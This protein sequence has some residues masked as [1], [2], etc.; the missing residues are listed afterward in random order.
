MTLSPTAESTLILRLL[1]ERGALRGKSESDVARVIA[2][3]SAGAEET[4]VANGLAD[5]KTIA[6]AYAKHLGIP[7][8]ESSAAASNARALA[9]APLRVHR[10]G[11]APIEIGS[12][13]AI[14]ESCRPFADLV[15]EEVCRRARV[16]PIGVT[17]GSLDLACA[18]P[19]SF[20]MLEEVQLR[21]GL[22]VRA[23]AATLSVADALIAGFFAKP[24]AEAAVVPDAAD[25]TAQPEMRDPD[26]IDLQRNTS[27]GKDDH[28]L[29]IVRILLR[30]AI[31]QG[32]SDVHLEPD[33]N[34][35]RVRYRIDGKLVDVAPPPPELFRP[36]IARVMRLAKAEAGDE[37][38][39][40]C[41]TF[42][43]KHFER[44]FHFRASTVPTVHGERMLVR[45]LDI[46]GA[47]A[48]FSDLG[49][50]DAPSRALLEAVRAR[51]LVLLA[52]EHG[53][54]TTTT[55]YAC[56]RALDPAV[57]SVASVEDP[58]EQR[59][60]RVN[61]I[62]ARACGG[63]DVASAL[64]AVLRQDPDVIAV[65]ELR[66]A[67]T[68]RVAIEA[69]RSGRSVIAA[70]RAASAL[71]ALELLADFGIAPQS[72]ASALRAVAAQRLVRRVCTACEEIVELDEA[73]AQRLGLASSTR[74]HRSRG[75]SCATCRGS[76]TK[77]RSGLFEVV[78]MTAE[79]RSC[80][81]HRASRDELRRA[82]ARSGATFFADAARAKL[83]AGITSLD[84]VRE[85]LR[86]ADAP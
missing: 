20:W 77:G 4:L 35:V 28:V 81:A 39:P 82:A 3:S 73:E 76:G 40:R 14:T 12:V 29:R 79:L 58:V 65:G 80:I 13:R 7:W 84:E 74:V 37:R 69:A 2:A 45:V 56:L 30:G 18:N 27:A 33:E 86:A 22:L 5:E 83:V 15:S 44:H 72:L 66:D 54:G 25:A 70:A 38:A 32:A 26:I 8:L 52:G 10:D 59:L 47:S 6:E 34:G 36:T 85:L 19:S 21:C 42:T 46:A 11:E 49:L 61:Q 23:H 51:G 53:A 78:P 1:W 57:A 17:Q 16:A 31:D 43:V 67:E 41:G 9:D 48:S 68:A 62:E 63:A 75:G 24:G 50:D 55:L 71:E 64:R 60:A